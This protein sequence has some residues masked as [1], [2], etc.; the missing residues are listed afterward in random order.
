MKGKNMKKQRIAILFDK[1][2]SMGGLEQFAVNAM[3]EQIQTIK[4]R[5][6]EF[7]ILVTMVHFNHDVEFLET[8]A[9]AVALREIPLSSYQPDGGTALRDAIGL[10]ID[11]LTKECPE[12]DGDFLVVVITDGDDTSSSIFNQSHLAEK[13]QTM[14]D[15]GWTFTY[16]GTDDSLESAKAMNINNVAGFGGPVGVEGMVGPGGTIGQRGVTY[17]SK[18]VSAGLD[19]Y[20]CRSKAG[21]SKKKLASFEFFDDARDRKIAAEVKAETPDGS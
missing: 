3:N 20:L 1:S 6:D 5:A 17:A 13:I 15:R 14:K 10:T 16:L 7:D 4:A 12:S 11:T 21:H 8:N 9:P 2:G 18:R 19:S